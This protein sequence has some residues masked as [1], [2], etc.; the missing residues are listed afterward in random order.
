MM[1]VDSNSG[2][3]NGYIWVMCNGDKNIDNVLPT[4]CVLIQIEWEWI[5]KAYN[6]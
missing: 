4:V 6:Q 1:V 2:T 3:G 5:G